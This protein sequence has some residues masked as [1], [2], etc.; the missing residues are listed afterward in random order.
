[1]YHSTPAHDQTS[2][3]ALVETA[4]AS[5]YHLTVWDGEEFAV[6]R[7]TD[8]DAVWAALGETDHDKLQLHADATAPAFGWVD[9]IY[10]NGPGETLADYSDNERTRALVKTAEAKAGFE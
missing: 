9:L 10:G 2:A 5:G 3:R 6:K 1:M 7:S 4:L 8:F